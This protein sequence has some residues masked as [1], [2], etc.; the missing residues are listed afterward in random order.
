MLCV[1]NFLVVS[2]AIEMCSNFC[3]NH[4]DEY[5]DKPDIDLVYVAL[6]DNSGNERSC[7]HEESD[8]SGVHTMHPIT[9]ISCFFT[10]DKYRIRSK[11]TNAES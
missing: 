1:E 3:D 9:L 11:C 5:K 2:V 4:E 10:H 8:S 6:I 7:S